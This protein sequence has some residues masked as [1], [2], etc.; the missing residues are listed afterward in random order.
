MMEVTFWG[1]R[2]SLPSPDPE[3][4]R[5]GGNSS[6]VEVA[7][8]DGTVLILD[9]GSGMRRLG[10]KLSGTL[11]RIDV[12]LTHL[13]MDHIQGL[14]FFA[15]IY[16]PG[17]EVH[18]WGPPS[19]TQPLLGRLARYLS[20]PL[21]PVHLRDVPSAIYMH[22]LNG[23][24]IEIGPYHIEVSFVCHPNPTVGYRVSDGETIVTY[25]PDHEPALGLGVI[26]KD[27]PAWVS[28][29]GLADGADLLIHDAQYTDEEYPTHVGWGHSTMRQAFDFAALADVAM[30]VPFHHDPSHS[31][32]EI[33]RIV[34]ET[35]H[36]MNPPF[37]VVPAMEG[38]TVVL[39]DGKISTLPNAHNL[40]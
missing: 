5:M 39:E 37:A 36:E 13:H 7:R 16:Q 35:L 14:G 22:D 23:D 3:T 9:A 21:F 6:C 34:S 20:P 12:L 33:D 40:A 38:M 28:G 1:T 25:L 24:D 18:I 32:D 29:I 31:D 10:R 2:G 19:S 26:E 15:P 8:T 4:S 17:L 27:S 30:L 11:Q